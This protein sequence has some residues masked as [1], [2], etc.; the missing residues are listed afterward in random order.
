MP[1]GELNE[2]GRPAVL[3]IA[4]QRAAVSHN[5]SLSPQEA[6]NFSIAIW[7]IEKR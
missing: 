6:V 2:N 5:H 7:L 3:S 4:K 1:Y